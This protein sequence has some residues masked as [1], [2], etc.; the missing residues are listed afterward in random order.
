M[1]KLSSFQDRALWLLGSGL[2]LAITTGVLFVYLNP[3]PQWSAPM[4]LSSAPV[5]WVSRQQTLLRQGQSFG[6]APSVYRV[7]SLADTVKV[8]RP[9]APTIRVYAPSEYTSR[10]PKNSQ[11]FKETLCQSRLL[12]LFSGIEIVLLPS[13]REPR[14]SIEGKRLTLG[15]QDIG[16]EEVTALLIHEGSHHYDLTQHQDR[17]RFTQ[18]SWQ[19]D[20]VKK[21]DAQ[22]SDFVSGYALTNSYEDFAESVTFFLLFQ[23]EFYERAQNSEALMTKYQYI[24]HIFDRDRSDIQTSYASWVL[25]AYN[26]DTTRIFFDQKKYAKEQKMDIMSS[27]CFEVV[28]YRGLSP[29]L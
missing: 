1:Y 20:D 9:L 23:R 6:S 22:L 4:P 5:G 15:L 24:Q 27:S 18:I 8:S 16:P 28:E 26:W 12:P 17:W 3:D 2:F 29:D 25:A 10:F 11:A 14:A 13:A 21:A 19:S 7:A